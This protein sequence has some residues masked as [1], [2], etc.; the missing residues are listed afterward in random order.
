[1]L[2]KEEIY[3]KKLEKV[4]RRLKNEYIKIKGENG[5]LKKRILLKEK[6][7]E[8]LR[9]NLRS[10][11]KF[12]GEFR[13]KMRMVTG[14][15]EKSLSKLEN[16]GIINIKEKSPNSSQK[17]L[18]SVN[19]LQRE[20]ELKDSLVKV[21]KNEN[22]SLLKKNKKLVLVLEEKIKRA[23]EGCFEMKNFKKLQEVEKSNEDM[24]HEI[25]RLENECRLKDVQ[26]S[27]LE[28]DLKALT[29]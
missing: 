27:L 29:S 16:S 12:S 26:Y 15:L 4:L 13:N 2:T 8:G 25:N 3:I 28:Q 1:M 10:V 14:C 20:L 5:K 21:L 7:V 9:K 24:K 23:M 17:L 18:N 11:E 19:N 22:S 6:E